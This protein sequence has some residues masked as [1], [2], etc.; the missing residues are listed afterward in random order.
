MIRA[1]VFLILAISASA[2]TI[3]GIVV[4]G[5]GVSV[6]GAMVSLG[7]HVVRSGPDGSFRFVDVA[8]GDY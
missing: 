6:V 4:D 5:S 8:A 2:A 3:S 7:S 1:T